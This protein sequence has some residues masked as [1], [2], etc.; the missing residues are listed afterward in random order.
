MTDDYSVI[1]GRGEYFDALDAI[2]SGTGPVAVDAERASGYRYSQRAYLIQVYRR[3]SGIFLF[4]PPAIGGFGELQAQIGDEEWVLHAASQ[5]LTCLREVGLDPARIFD[6]E[7]AARLAGM[8]RVGLGT[9]VEELLGVHLAKEHSAADWS[10][11]PLP[12]S[13]LRYAAQDVELLVDVRDRLDEQ[14]AEAGKRDFAE[15]EFQATLERDLVI[16]RAEPWR[17]LS[18][19]HALRKPRNL[20]VARALWQAR[21]AYAREVD[22][23]PGRLVPDGAL[24][25][26]ARILPGSK[27]ELLGLKEFTGRA[28]RSQADRWWQALAAGLA[29]DDLPA[30]RAAGDGGPPPARAWADRNPEADARLRA[31]RTV[32]AELAESLELPVE[33]LLTP[34]YL[35]RVAWQPPEPAEADS[36]GEAL[37]ELGAREWQI[38]MTAQPIA[39]AFVEA[40]QSPPRPAESVS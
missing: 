30:V 7:L 19:L 33:N 36:I 5:D 8:P 40:L 4:D 24:V 3:G 29:D 26:V 14:L 27:R 15:Q 37:R 10:R 23:A 31:A 34:D 21:D 38:G 2:A 9:V 17:R 22:I 6:T 35:R 32:L 39:D 1:S 11:R 13:W 20:A 28:S 12:D 25:A 18:G 16:V